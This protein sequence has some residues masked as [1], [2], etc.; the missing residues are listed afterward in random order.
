[1]EERRTVAG[2]VPVIGIGETYPRSAV[3]NGRLFF[4]GRDNTTPQ[5]G[6][7]VTDGTAAG[8]RLVKEDLE[9]GG[10]AEGL[11]AVDTR[12][13]FTEFQG[14]SQGLWVSDGTATGTVFVS[15]FDGFQLTAAG[16]RLLFVR[17]DSELWTS[18]GTAAG[19]TAV[20][21]F[22]LKAGASLSG[23]T[24]V[25][26]R[27]FFTADDGIHGAELWKSDG[28]ALG[29]VLV[30][31]INPGS[32]GSGPSSLTN[33]DG[34][35]FFSADDG[36]SGAE[37]WKSD[38]TPAGTVRVQD[39]R[40]GAGS[41]DPMVFTV[42]G[43]HLFFTADDGAYGYALWAL[44]IAATLMVNSP[45]DNTTAADGACTLREA[46]ANVNVA[47]DTTGGDCAPG[48]GR[49]DTIEFDLP[50]PA[51]I[52]LTTFGGL[53]ISA[54]VTIRGPTTGALAVFENSAARPVFDITTGNVRIA[55]LTIQNG[56]SGM[57]VARGA[58][59]T[60]TDC[61]L[62]GNSVGVDN[63]GTATLTNCTVSDN[64]GASG[65]G[66]TNYG[67]ANLTNCTLSGN[68]A[69]YG[70]GGI[71]S[72]GTVTLTN[73]TL[74]GNSGEHGIGGIAIFSGTATLTNTIVANSD[75]GNCMITSESTLMS[76]GHNLSDDNTCFASPD[77]VHTDPRLAPLANYGGPTATM[78][79][80]TAVGI[81]DPSCKGPSPAIDAGDDGVIGSPLN[82]S[83]DQRGLPRK[84][85]VHVD[86]GAVESSAT[87]CVGDCG[88][89]GN[90]TVNELVLM[91]NIAIG[92][93]LV[94]AC[95]PGDKNGDA[96]ITVDEL[97]TAVNNSLNGCR[98]NASQ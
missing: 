66:I 26:E 72:L 4:T 38:G 59:L 7:W 9:S 45:A 79:L 62:S 84:L 39:I 73:C 35:L 18:D 3:L 46:I 98:A 94:T 88:Y 27:L 95:E 31:D 57:S 8:T 30:K 77:V 12:L 82:L 76:D 54:D 90:V 29:T 50:L 13:F 25:N 16:T 91:V 20:K 37:P 1:V 96:N 89:D 92:N 74:S 21:Q 63:G 97:V 40:P 47:A 80:C 67:T 6:L 43:S 55:N 52:T 14:K 83:T 28:T 71:E 81:P 33:V 44:P 93:A 53:T 64:F 49:G 5:F 56:T 51:T 11:T 36:N 85:G 22:P 23:L 61:T 65:T 42:S 75:G 32:A 78:A 2:T 87:S 15:A 19:T 48:T 69:L 58:S 34:M 86:I 60:L 17:N 10:H 24:S 70:A 68:H 41:S